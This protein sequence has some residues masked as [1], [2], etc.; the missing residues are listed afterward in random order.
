MTSPSRL[1]LFDLDHTLL[2]LDSDYQWADF[3]A[4]TGRAGDPAEAQRR[5]EELMDRYN[6]GEL[7]AEESAEFMLGLLSRASLPELAEWHEVFMAEVIRP[8][9]RRNAIDLVQEHMTGGDLCAI[10]T[11]TNDFVTAPIARAFGI[12]HLIAT[13]AELHKGRYTG[14]IEGVPSFQAGKITRVDAWL[15]G[16]GLSRD[17]FQEVHFYSDSTNDLPLLEVASHPVATNP[18]P[19]LREIAQERGWKVL[20]LFTELQDEKS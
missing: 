1:V 10:V 15:E 4:R 9:M 6:A 20:D 8:A 16:M 2:P 3:L 13:I 17:A 19:A 18:S 12:P 7:T 5:N 11:A 14:R